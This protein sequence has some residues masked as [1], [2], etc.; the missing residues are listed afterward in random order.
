MVRE[1]ES[2]DVLLTMEAPLGNV[3]QIPD[4]KK[5]ILSQRVLLVKTKD[6]LLR[7]FLAHYMKGFFFQKQLSL[8]PTGS[9]AK[10]IQRRKLDGL[11]IYLP[12]TNAEQSAIAAILS[13]MDAEITA[14]EKKLTKARQLKQ[15][16]M[17]E[18]LMGRIRLV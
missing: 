17:Q 15:G 14:L 12:S 2:G 7:D 11:P 5:Y 9:T 10:G 18:L 6:W 16:M 1:C 8:N 3:A 13:D 4:S